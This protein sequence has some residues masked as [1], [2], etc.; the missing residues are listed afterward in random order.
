[1]KQV[2]EVLIDFGVPEPKVCGI[3]VE[4]YMCSFFMMNL[5]YDG[6]YR[7]VKL[8]KFKLMRDPND[9]TLIPRIVDGHNQLNTIINTTAS[10][11]RTIITHYKDDNHNTSTIYTSFKRS[12]CGTPK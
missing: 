9:V 6:K 2:L 12:S 4:R 3:L 1:M 7:M 8:S 11:I 5:A 10:K